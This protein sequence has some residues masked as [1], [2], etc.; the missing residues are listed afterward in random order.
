MTEARYSATTEK[1]I[2]GDLFTAFIEAGAISKANANDPKKSQLV[3]CARTDKGVHASGNI[4]SLKLIIED[5][6]VVEKINSHLSPQIRVWG[7]QRT[8]NSFSAYQACD[9]RWYEYLIPSNSFLPP[10]PSCVFAKR[11]K[12]LA[13]QY[14]DLDGYNSRQEEVN[15]FWNKVEEETIKPIL[16]GLP[17]DIRSEVHTALYDA[18]IS[19]DTPQYDADE[20]MR[21]LVEG[22]EDEEQPQTEEGAT[23]EVSRSNDTSKSGNCIK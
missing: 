16:D 11:L 19:Q 20:F 22:S 15:D 14:D 13:E 5:K 2:E 18:E 6:D 3:R 23:R 17:Q 12:E 4:I 1:T 8:T 10:H 21:D 9:S 7:I